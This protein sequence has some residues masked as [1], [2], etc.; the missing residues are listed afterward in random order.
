MEQTR[1]DVHFSLVWYQ[2]SISRFA[3]FSLLNSSPRVLSSLFFSFSLPTLSKTS[4]PHQDRKATRINNFKTV[5]SFHDVNESNLL[6]IAPPSQ[7]IASELLPWQKPFQLHFETFLEPHKRSFAFLRSFL[8]LKFSPSLQESL[9]GNHLRS[10]KRGMS[11]SISTKSY[12]LF[13]HITL[14]FLWCLALACAGLALWSATIYDDGVS[15][16]ESQKRLEHLF[17]SSALEGLR[18]FDHFL[19]PN[20]FFSPFSFLK[21][22]VT[23]RRRPAFPLPFSFD[24]LCLYHDCL[25]YLDFDPLHSL[26]RQQPESH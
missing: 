25:S 9:K 16:L 5:D 15:R 13:L 4:P 11:K 7:E 19:F 14:P 17:R 12:R 24:S 1:F 21:F 26:V 22:K 20:A 23:L 6:L 2:P 8:S 18:S 10:T 3:D